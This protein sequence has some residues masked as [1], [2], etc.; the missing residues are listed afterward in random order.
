VREE[1]WSREFW[2]IRHFLSFY[3]VP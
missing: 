1:D 3:A 2:R